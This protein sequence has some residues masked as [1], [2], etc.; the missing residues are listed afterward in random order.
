MKGSHNAGDKRQSAPVGAVAGLCCLCCECEGNVRKSQISAVKLL[1]SWASLLCIH[2]FP[3]D[4]RKMATWFLGFLA[5][6]SDNLHFW[7]EFVL[8]GHGKI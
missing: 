2:D 1:L 4:E 7:A 8:K 5:K 6:D 3:G